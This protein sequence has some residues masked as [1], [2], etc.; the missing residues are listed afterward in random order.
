MNKLKKVI[1]ILLSL[2]III[3]FASCGNDIPDEDVTDNSSSSQIIDDVS[4]EIK[5]LSLNK[6][7]VCDYEWHGDSSVMLVRSEYTDV[8]LDKSLEKQYPLLAKVLSETSVMRKR[9]MEDEKDNYV[10]F[11]SEAYKN[12]SESF[13]TYVSTLDVQV[14]RADGVAVSILEDYFS[15]GCRDFNGINYDSESGKELVLS[16]VFTDVSKIPA[17]VEKELLSRLGENKPSGASAVIE[18]FKNTSDDSITWVLD[19]NGVTFYFNP[20]D[21]ALPT[22]AFRQ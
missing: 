18:Y 9:A 20:G 1:S 21:I 17:T 13:S 7:C 6:E 12:D 5:A 15:D 3:S 22:S 10:A 19:Y 8:T 4:E 11:A 2:C 14:R 16:D